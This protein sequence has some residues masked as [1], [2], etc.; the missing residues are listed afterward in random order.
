MVGKSVPPLP[1]NGRRPPPTGRPRWWSTTSPSGAT[2]A[3]SPWT[4]V[5]FTVEAGELVGIAG[6][7]GNGQTR[8]LRGGARAA[9]AERG[10]GQRRRHPARPERRPRARSR[11][12][13]S[14]SPRTRSTDAVVPGMTVLQHLVARRRPAAHEG[15]RRRRLEGGPGRGRRPRGGPSPQ[16]R[17]PRPP[18]GD[19]VGR[20]HAAGPLHPARHAPTPTLLVARLPEPW[21]RH[22]HRSGRPGAAARAPGRRGAAW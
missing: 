14:G 10:L 12:A 16:P 22:R 7:S 3:T 21:P 17:R 19:A 15:P 2:A 20:Q 1:A 13:S 9:R 6:V 8:A 11:P 5:T 4:D 18:G